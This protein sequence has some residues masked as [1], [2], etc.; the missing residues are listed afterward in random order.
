MSLTDDNKPHDPPDFPGTEPPPKGKK[1]KKH[2]AESAA[3]VEAVDTWWRSIFAGLPT[4]VHNRMEPLLENLKSDIR[5]AIVTHIPAD[6][7]D[8][9]A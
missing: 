5:K 9:E 7:P 1:P 3:A 6:S 8:M 2:E 4:E